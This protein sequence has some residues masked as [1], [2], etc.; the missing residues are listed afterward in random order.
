MLYKINS[1][2]SGKRYYHDSRKHS[3][4][5]IAVVKTAIKSFILI[6]KLLFEGE[7]MFPFL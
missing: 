1:Y 5:E 2:S 6:V 7:N 4:Y 3:Q